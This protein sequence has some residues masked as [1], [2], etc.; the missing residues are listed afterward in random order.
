MAYEII[1]KYLNN[2]LKPQLAALELQDVI[3]SDTINSIRPQMVSCISHWNDERFRNALLAVG[4]EEAVF[5]RPR[6]DIAVRC[7]VVVTIRNSV[8]ETVH[9]LTTN[10]FWKGKSISPEVIREITSAAIEY[11]KTVDFPALSNEISEI[12]NDLYND[13]AAR[14]PIA[15]E[16]LAQIG[17][18]KSQIIE[19][20]SVKRED[21][22]NL[23]NLRKQKGAI[24]ATLD[25]GR[26]PRSMEE[27]SDGYELSISQELRDGINQRINDRVP[28]IV[29]SFKG[30]S[31][32]IE[33][34]LTIMEYMMG[35][36]GFIV[37]S[38][39]LIANGHIER[40]LELIKPGH[41]MA[42]MIN[43]WKNQKG[44]AKNHKRWLQAAL[45]VAEGRR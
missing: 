24:S 29:D 39:Y 21:E 12:E 18:N 7:F 42:A 11:F 2:V 35:N 25:N 16:A 40:R 30:I 4:C 8:L 9:S 36:G 41:S 44:L 27:L 32:N 6:A 33:K 22:P 13:F 43:N 3:I 34:L 5:Y 15:W 38:N 26:N 31:R 14:Y 23:R 20:E 17:E 45:D 19:Y 37:T 1:E 28:F 10:V